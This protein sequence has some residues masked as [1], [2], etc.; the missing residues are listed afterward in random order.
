L[1]GI[2]AKTAVDAALLAQAGVA[3]APRFLTGAY[4]LQ[5]LH[6]AELGDAARTVVSLGDDFSITKV[7]IKPY[8]CCRSTHAA[9][10]AAL[11]LRRTDPQFAKRVLRVHAIV[12]K[13]VYKRCGTPFALG[14]EPRLSAQ[15]SIPFTMALALRCGPPT[16]RDFAPAAVVEASSRDA[17]LIRHIEVEA[18]RGGSSDLLTPVA[19]T[20][21]TDEHKISVRV[22]HVP[23]GPEAPPTAD[24]QIGK[25]A[26]AA[27]EHLDKSEQAALLAF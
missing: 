2:A 26:G 20:F 19:A 23:G 8:P 13:G 6:G 27:G 5:S 7:G 11:K 9:I 15:F 21:D 1:A 4:G 24:D 14:D 25:L 12:P 16:L 17:E 18:D 10:A 3:G 22:D